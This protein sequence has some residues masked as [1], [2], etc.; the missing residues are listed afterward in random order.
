M[1][2][3]SKPDFHTC[4]ATSVNIRCGINEGRTGFTVPLDPELCLLGHFTTFKKKFIEKIASCMKVYSND[5]EVSLWIH[6]FLGNEHIYSQKLKHLSK[7][8]AALLKLYGR[9]AN[10]DIRFDI[11][12]LSL[13]N[14]YYIDYDLLLFQFG[15]NIGALFVCWLFNL[16]M[17]VSKAWCI[18]GEFILIS[19][20]L[21][22][23]VISGLIVKDVK[24]WTSGLYR[25]VVSYCQGQ[26]Y[27]LFMAF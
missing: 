6:V 4:R 7:H 15:K 10:T 3:E 19:T 23:V 11:K 12:M 8:L 24:L 16:N 20:I 13:N 22:F 26:K 21:V 14:N 25:F 27:D 2:F 1:I 5:M 9:F 17:F 18:I